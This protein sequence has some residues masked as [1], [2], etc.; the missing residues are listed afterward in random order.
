M[1][2][3]PSPTNGLLC[4]NQGANSPN[5]I[6]TSPKIPSMWQATAMPPE[7]SVY[8]LLFFKFIFKKMKIFLK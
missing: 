2:T 5:P 4:I 7:E 3:S 1:L 6:A 8:L